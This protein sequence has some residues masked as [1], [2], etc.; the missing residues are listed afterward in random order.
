MNDVAQFAI[1]QW[2]DFK[3]RSSCRDYWFGQLF[4]LF[5]GALGIS[6]AVSALQNWNQEPSTTPPFWGVPVAVTLL[7]IYLV[8]QFLLAIRRL[9][10]SDKSGFWLLIGLI[11]V[12]GEL[13]LMVMLLLPGNSEENRYGIPA[14]IPDNQTTT[15]RLLI[16]G[17]WILLWSSLVIALIMLASCLPM[18]EKI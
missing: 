2:T 18:P 1:R 10:D 6:L 14:P 3:G 13:I 12:V 11:P 5:I 16:S 8:P 7:I 15:Q 17:F 9:H 4:W